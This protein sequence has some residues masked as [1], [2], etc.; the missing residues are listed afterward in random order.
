MSFLRSAV[1]YSGLELTICSKFSSTL[2][3]LS[4]NVEALIQSHSVNRR[5]LVRWSGAVYVPVQLVHSKASQVL[6]FHSFQRFYCISATS[7]KRVPCVAI[8]QYPWNISSNMTHHLFEWNCKS[9]SEVDFKWS[10]CVVKG[11][12]NVKSG[13]GVKIWS[14]CVDFKWSGC[15]L[16]GGASGALHHLPPSEMARP[17][18]AYFSCFLFEINL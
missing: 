3:F 9:K 16:E 18:V 14:G 12:E 7:V 11:D 17:Q 4:L 6:R 10:G 15:A 5:S 13:T 1:L 8:M 2:N